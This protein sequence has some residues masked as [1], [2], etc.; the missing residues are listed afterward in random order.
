MMRKFN[1]FR[2]MAVLFPTCDEKFSTKRLNIERKWCA[3]K[4]SWGMW[5]GGGGAVFG[6]LRVTVVKM[7][8]FSFFSLIL[9]IQKWGH[10][11]RSNSHAKSREYDTWSIL[12]PGENDRKKLWDNLGGF[13]SFCFPSFVAQIVSISKDVFLPL[14]KH[15]MRIGIWPGLLKYPLLEWETPRRTLAKGL[16]QSSGG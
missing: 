6:I 1:F 12:G 5:G 4:T 9:S 3:N 16:L 8:F 2:E 11:Q 14:N 15:R 10:V 7:V 13:P